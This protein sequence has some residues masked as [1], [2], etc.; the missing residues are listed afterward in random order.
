M[1]PD[2]PNLERDLETAIGLVWGHLRARQY[3]Q[4]S[5]LARG[6]LALWP[7]QPLLLLLGAYA[8]GE[9]GEAPAAPVRALPRQPQYAALAALIAR[10]ALEP[11]GEAA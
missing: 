3:R 11:A 8:A 4:A 5:L 2:T 7:E 6:A 1:T 9:L 10:R